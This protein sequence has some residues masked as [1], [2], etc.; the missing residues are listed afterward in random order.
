[1]LPQLFFRR[2]EYIKKECENVNY[3]ITPGTELREQ[4]REKGKA[5]KSY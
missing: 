1:M 4:K 3:P 2:P 5:K